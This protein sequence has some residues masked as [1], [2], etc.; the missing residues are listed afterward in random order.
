M[1][2]ILVVD[3]DDTIRETL[4]ELLSE[5]YECDTAET[6]EQA[7]S[8]L[9]AAS[10]DLVLT[11]IT[12]PGLSGVDLLGLIREKYPATRVILIS[13]IGDQ[14]RAQSLIALGAFDFILKPFSLETV[15]QA[16]RRAVAGGSG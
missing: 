16:V 10:Y 12:M 15:E 7:L 5:D 11:D 4:D 13:G 1:A 9:E 2:T 3:D 6:A 14:E 8:K